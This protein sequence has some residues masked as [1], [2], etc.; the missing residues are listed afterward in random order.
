M[1]VLKQL[2]EGK[3]SEGKAVKRFEQALEREFKMRY[4]VAV[5]SGTSALH[6]ALILSGVGEGD[7]VILPA[8]TFVAT[9]LAILYCGATPVFAD[10]GMDGNIDLESIKKKV[11][12][13]TKAIIAVSWGG[14]PCDLYE[15]EEMCRLN[16]WR[17][18]Q[19]N[20]HGLGAEYEGL[21][22]SDYGDFSCYSFQAIKALSTGDGGL[23]ASTSW[24][25]W[26]RA[27]KLRWFGIDREND[28][29]DETGERVYNLREVGYKYHMN[30][31]AASIGLGNLTGFKGRLE[32]VRKIA[33]MYDDC[34][35]DSG[36][37]TVVGKKEGCSYWL[38]DILVDNRSDFMRAMKDRDI[39]VSV[40]H[41]GI[42]HNQVL[43]GKQQDLPNQRYWDTHHV[44]L[45]I[46]ASMTDEDV[47][48]VL[49]AVRGGW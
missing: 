7:E 36:R 49:E 3:L 46:H 14:N 35:Q 39:P 26:N 22:L 15:L 37:E 6:L 12:K 25:G 18:I 24:N 41:L 29:P 2:E 45:P 11:S 19:D 28:K 23:L 17:L 44:C 20:A 13:K 27:R 34:I 10:I 4:A 40:V 33:N 43:G 1:S 5:N 16:K 30:D 21:P 8:Q 48:R 47:G 31:V 38:Y 32:R 42:D 9:G